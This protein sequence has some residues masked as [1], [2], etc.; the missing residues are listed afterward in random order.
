MSGDTAQ[1]LAAPRWTP[2]ALTLDL[3][4]TLWPVRP[5]LQRADDATAAWLAEH[6]PAVAADW[7]AAALLAERERIAAN[8]PDVAHDFSALRRLALEHAFA[9]HGIRDAPVGTLW[10]IYFAARND[11]TPYADSPA[12]LRRL[13]RRVPLASLTNGNADLDR[14]GVREHFACHVC[15]RDVGCAKPD[16]RIFAAAA[17]RLGVAPGDIL[18]AGDDPLLDVA[19]ARDAG[20]HAAWINRDGSAWPDGLGAPPE[21]ELPDLAALADWLDSRLAAA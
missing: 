13:A 2:R 14:T 17:L 7:T 11:V 19:A 9:A 12:A 5:A 18:H 20:F 1:T 16:P 3:D 4:D 15:A 10:D 21:I 6:Y 8:R